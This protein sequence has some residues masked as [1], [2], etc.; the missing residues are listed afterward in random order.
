MVTS[1][2]SLCLLLIIYYICET[3][4]SLN[5]I[6]KLRERRKTKNNQNT[7]LYFGGNLFLHGAL[8]NP[9]HALTS[10]LSRLQAPFRRQGEFPV[11]A[12]F[13]ELGIGA[14]PLADKVWLLLEKIFLISLPTC[15]SLP[16]TPS[17][18]RL[19]KTYNGLKLLIFFFP[20]AVKY[21]ALRIAA[22]KCLL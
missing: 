9:S 7:F 3:W 13:C 19:V 18:S 5:H 12:N 4:K 16:D 17:V 2:R 22:S 6:A 21:K 15:Q 8:G 14:W 20:A 10:Q 1:L 11:L